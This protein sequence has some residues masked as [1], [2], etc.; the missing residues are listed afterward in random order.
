MAR[1]TQRTITPAQAGILLLSPYDEDASGYRYPDQQK[2][3]DALVDAGLLERN[4]TA[5]DRVRI[6]EDGEAL[7]KY[8][9]EAHNGA[10]ED[11]EDE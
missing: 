7:L 10:E 3:V 8:L 5:E 4:P 9:V 1:I 2:D 6:T 11:D